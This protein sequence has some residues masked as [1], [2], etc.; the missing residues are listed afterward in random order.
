MRILII[1]DDE[2]LS[3]ATAVHLRKENWDVDIC[4]NG[5]DGLYCLKEGVYD[6]VLLDR[7]MS[8]MDGITMLELARQAGVT[9]PVL[10]LTALGQIGDKIAG[11]EAGAD[12]YLVKPFDIREL[13]ARIKALVRRP[14]EIQLRQEVH[15]GDLLLDISALTLEGS[16]ARCSLSK[17][18][19]EFLGVLIKSGGQTISRHALFSR[20]WGMESDIEESALDNYAHFIRRRLFAVSANVKLVTVRGVGYRLEETPC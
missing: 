16:K 6:L 1:E 19:G 5:E 18:E 13:K 10:M 17:K 15:F 2:A 14:G 11:F 12:D 9:A 8:G 7:M 4:T 3:N 20:V